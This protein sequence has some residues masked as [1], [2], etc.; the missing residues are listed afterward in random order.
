MGLIMKKLAKEKVRAALAK[1]GTLREFSERCLKE[2]EAEDSIA[3]IVN[4]RVRSLVTRYEEVRN[5]INIY[6]PQIGRQMPRVIFEEPMWWRDKILAILQDIIIGCRTAE[7][8]LR[9][10]IESYVEESILDRLASLRAELKSLKDRG[11]DI[12]VIRNL[13]EA[14]AEAEQG[15]WLAS[16]MISSRVI[17]YV[18]DKIP[19]DKDE[20]KVRYLIKR[21][22]LPKDRRDVQQRVIT[23]MR[24]SRNFLSHRV[25]LFPDPEDALMLLGG[26][27]SLTR[28][29]LRIGN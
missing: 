29:L 28:L 20:D 21:G 5:W 25:D 10:M 15:H 11:L 27:F 13:D 23:S 18:V 8:G 6:I 9:A 24:L 7:Q 17:S 1:I 14:I 19:G 3:I 2:V 26:A 4:E 16:A 12:N 22:A